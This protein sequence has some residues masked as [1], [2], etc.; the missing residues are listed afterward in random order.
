[1]TAIQNLEEMVLKIDQCETDKDI[2]DAYKH[3]A[4]VIK[5]TMSRYGL[6]VDSVEE[7]LDMVREVL[8]DANEVSQ[9][10]PSVEIDVE[11]ER[12][13]EELLKN[14]NMSDFPKVPT[15]PMKE[16]TKQEERFPMMN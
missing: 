14:T 11:T 8:S 9:A 1:M 16:E 12:E 3:G 7:T 13:F 5:H 6:N 15:Q 2:L 10:M 4:E